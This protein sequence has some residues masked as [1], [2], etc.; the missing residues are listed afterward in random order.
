MA[1]LKA[2]K[3]A[4]IRQAVEKLVQQAKDGD[5]L[6]AHIEIKRNVLGTV[7]IKLKSGAMMR[8]VPDTHTMS[9]EQFY[10]FVE[11]A[12]VWLRNAV[13]IDTEDP[14]S[15]GIRREDYAPPKES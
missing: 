6:Q 7:P 1:L 2:V 3:P 12:R 14:S 10:D 13:G 11:R 4:D 8:I 9:T 15:Y 5:R